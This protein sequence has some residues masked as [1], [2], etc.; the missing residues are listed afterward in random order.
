[1]HTHRIAVTVSG[2]VQLLV[3]AQIDCGIS[4]SSISLLIHSVAAE[5]SHRRTLLSHDLLNGNHFKC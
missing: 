3:V 5:L 4:S 1:M 2:P